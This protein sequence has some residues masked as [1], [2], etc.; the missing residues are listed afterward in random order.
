MDKQ[1]TRKFTVS[2]KERI[3]SILHESALSKFVSV[4]RDVNFLTPKS[5]GCTFLTFDTRYDEFG[6]KKEIN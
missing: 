4:K 3:A 6:I 5:V 2:N 1:F